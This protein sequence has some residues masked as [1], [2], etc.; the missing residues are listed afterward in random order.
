MFACGV[1]VGSEAIIRFGSGHLL[2]PRHSLPSVE[3]HSPAP[4]VAAEN[5]SGVDER[6]IPINGLLA[7]LRG[8]GNWPAL[9]RDQ[10]FR[11]HQ[12]EVPISTTLGDIR[13]D[14]LIYRLEP[15]LILLSECKS[16][17][18]IEGKQARRYMA[19]DASW[20]R[21]AGVIPHELA[22]IS[23]ELT[24]RTMFVGRE[25][26]RADLEH[27]LVQLG[28]EAPLLTIGTS[29]VRL[30]GASSIVGLDDFDEQHDVG[31]P[32]AR[33]PVD[34]Q[35]GDDDLLEL[36]IPQIIA[37]QARAEEILSVESIAA[38]ILPEWVVL[39]HSARQSF[40]SRLEPLLAALSSGEFRG[41]FRYERAQGTGDRGRV[42][43]EAT[44]ATRD[45]R[46]RTQAWQAQ[47]QRAARALRRRPRAELQGQMSLDELAY[48]GGLADE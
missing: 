19:A 36:L 26:R 8:D 3:W 37:A 48:Q 46:G 15:R 43:I 38:T 1:Q 6:L 24:V 25:E 28:I 14:A 47:Q 17:R 29:R 18:N 12:L 16:G 35:S 7:L 45:P 32:P 23:G 41:Q 44:P 10:G 30:S 31:L 27:G 4:S 34:H 2:E 40:V 5:M 9:L 20:L 42:V 33:I 21:R 13:A 39:S 11:R 22:G